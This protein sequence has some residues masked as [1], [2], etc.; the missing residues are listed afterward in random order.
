MILGYIGLKQ[1]SS[2]WA[3]IHTG[4]E[5]FRIDTE[6]GA[7]KYSERPDHNL[8]SQGERINKQV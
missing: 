6:S 1:Y 4:L 2:I 8:N 3:M 5:Q 7:G